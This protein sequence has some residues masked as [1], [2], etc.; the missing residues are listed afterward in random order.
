MK[1]KILLVQRGGMKQSIQSTQLETN[2]KSHLQ[3]SKD[4]LRL[5]GCIR[6]A[7]VP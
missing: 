1:K 7:E 2:R 6:T 3:T 4:N 5:R